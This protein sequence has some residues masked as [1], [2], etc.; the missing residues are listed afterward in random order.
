MLNVSTD[1]CDM[2]LSLELEVDGGEVG[3]FP[4]YV[5]SQYFKKVMQKNEVGN[6]LQYVR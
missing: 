4:Y 2:I 3:G 6:I 1:N 5:T